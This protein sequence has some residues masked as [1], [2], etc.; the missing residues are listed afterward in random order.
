MGASASDRKTAEK[1]AEYIRV[2]RARNRWTQAEFAQRVGLSTPY[3]S[4][5]ER[6]IADP[7]LSTVERIAGELG[8]SLSLIESAA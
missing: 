5:I 6:G 1:L 3:V 8:L 2:G 4:E 7:Q